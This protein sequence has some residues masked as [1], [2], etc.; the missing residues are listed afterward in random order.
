[1]LLPFLISFCLSKSKI[2]ICNKKCSP[3]CPSERY[4][5]GSLN[6][7]YA[8]MIQCNKNHKNI[9]IYFYSETNDFTIEFTSNLFPDSQIYFKALS[10]SQPVNVIIQNTNPEYNKIIQI[11]P[12]QQIK[13]TH[14]KDN[15]SNHFTKPEIEKPSKKLIIS[16]EPDASI[17]TNPEGLINITCDKFQYE[18]WGGAVCVENDGANHGSYGNSGKAKYTFIG[19]KVHILAYKEDASGTADIFIDGIFVENAN[20]NSGGTSNVD[21]FPGI[22]FSST[23]L[24]YNEHTI[25][26]IPKGMIVIG[27]LYIN[28]LPREGSYRLGFE[29]FGQT[30]GTWNKNTNSNPPTFSCNEE[31]SKGI[32]YFYGTR[33]WLTGIR[34]SS[35]GEFNLIIDDGTPIS[36]NERKT[37]GYAQNN[38]PILLYESEELEFKPHQVKIIRTNYEIKLVNLLYTMYPYTEVETPATDDTIINNPVGLIN[39]T[40]DKLTYTNWGNA[41]CVSNGYADHAS[42]SNSVDASAKYTFKGTR[43]HILVWKEGNSGLANIIVDHYIIATRNLNSG[44]GN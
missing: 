35:N 29:E 36:I 38:M 37:S 41:I 32:F 16:Q 18:S 15:F 7:I 11:Y 28:P 24:E 19:T 1:M 17:L 8:K 44:G 23:E 39:I 2:C 30:S 5:N 43:A 4:F 10:D 22:V 33:F 20:F 27:S 9:E 14:I 31:G 21:R 26:I 3:F 13:L 12:N 25:E 34:S 40:C 42:Y 6:D